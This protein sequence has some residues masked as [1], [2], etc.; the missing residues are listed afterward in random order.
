MPA[1][2][3][4]PAKPAQFSYIAIGSN[5]IETTNALPMRITVSGDFRVAGPTSRHA[6]FNGHPFAVSLAAFLGQREAVIVHAEQVEDG[7]GASDYSDLPIDD[8]PT[9]GFHRREQCFEL[10]AEDVAGDH[11]PAWLRDNGWDPKG[12]V[13]LDQ[14]FANTPDHNQEVV[15][16][17]AVRGVDCADKPTVAAALAALRAKVSVQRH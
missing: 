10:S 8:W 3:T 17:L 15:I 16:S 7:S 2:A 1:P 9:A 12:G 13:A 5:A 6:V 14:Y 4:N 11:D